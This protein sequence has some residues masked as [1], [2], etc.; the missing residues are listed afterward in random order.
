M[1]F[2]HAPSL[3]ASRP[4]CSPDGYAQD[5]LTSLSQ[6]TELEDLLKPVLEEHLVIGGYADS[7]II[8]DFIAELAADTRQLDDQDSKDALS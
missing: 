4:Y 7:G 3:S 6:G 2:E 5:Q 8:R 1:P